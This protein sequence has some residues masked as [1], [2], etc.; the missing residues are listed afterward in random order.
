MRLCDCV[1]PLP[2]FLL[3]TGS[4]LQ[5]R[6]PRGP[7]A[8]AHTLRALFIYLFVPWYLVLSSRERSPARLPG[9][10]SEARATSWPSA[11]PSV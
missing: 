7:Q 4:A 6:R 2:L 9:A 5:G 3:V 10:L 1:F 11:L 8:S